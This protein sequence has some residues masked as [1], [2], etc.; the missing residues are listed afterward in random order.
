MAV[1]VYGFIILWAGGAFS[2]GLAI[3][4]KIIIGTEGD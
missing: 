1:Y 4:G 2:V 3:D